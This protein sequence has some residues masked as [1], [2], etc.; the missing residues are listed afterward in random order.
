LKLLNQFSQRAAFVLLA[1]NKSQSKAHVRDA[2]NDFTP[3]KHQVMSKV[4]FQPN[5]L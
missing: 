3:G 5:K 1:E 4:H 2:V